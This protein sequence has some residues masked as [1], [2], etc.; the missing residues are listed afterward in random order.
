MKA[1]TPKK[2]TTF[3]IIDNLYDLK[4]HF[5]EQQIINSIKRANL[6]LKKEQK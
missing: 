6:Y 1:N 4:K 5:E 2:K 3:E